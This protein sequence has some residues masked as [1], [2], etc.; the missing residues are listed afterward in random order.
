MIRVASV[1][2]SSYGPGLVFSLQRLADWAGWPPSVAEH[3]V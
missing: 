1:V 2:E 3:N